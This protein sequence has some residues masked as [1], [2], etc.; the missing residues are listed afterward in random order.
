MFDQLTRIGEDLFGGAAMKTMTSMVEGATAGAM[1]AATGQGGGKADAMTAAFG[2]YTETAA[3]PSPSGNM[4]NDQLLEAAKPYGEEQKA[5]M[6]R[7]HMHEQEQREEDGFVDKYK[8]EHGGEAPGPNEVSAF[9]IGSRYNNGGPTVDEDAKVDL[10]SPESRLKFLATFSQNNAGGVATDESDKDESKCGATAMIGAMILAKGD[11]GVKDLV[12]AMEAGAPKG[13]PVIAPELRK[14]IMAGE[15][16]TTRDL[17][18]LKDGAYIHFNETVEHDDPES[19]D[20]KVTGLNVSTMQTFIDENP[21]IKEAFKEHHMSMNHTDTDGDGVGNHYT[22][23]LNDSHMDPSLV[24]D[25]LSRFAGPDAPY[26]AQQIIANPRYLEEYRNA[27]RNR[28]IAH[29]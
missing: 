5:S 9:K 22:V 29:E 10:S 11:Q 6:G 16:L 1:T 17:N 26:M 28:I 14:K 2:H 18:M 27:T 3:K 4:T 25:P 15:Q 13:A 21:A 12:T 23:S 19:K 20:P 7:L 8:S 24:Y